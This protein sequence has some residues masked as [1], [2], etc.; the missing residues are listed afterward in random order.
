MSTED[1]N[2]SP[3]TSRPGEIYTVEGRVRSVGVLARGLRRSSPRGRRYRRA[4]VFTGIRVAL[5]LG[6]VLVLVA[7]IVQAVA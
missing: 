6:L 7:V 5:T 3:A 2:W 1:S 4:M